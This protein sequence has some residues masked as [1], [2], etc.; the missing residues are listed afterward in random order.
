MIALH[1]QCLDVKR[2]CWCLRK[3]ADL[4][5]WAHAVSGDEDVVCVLHSV[6]TFEITF[7][8]HNGGNYLPGKY[9]QDLGK[10]PQD[11]CSFSGLNIPYEKT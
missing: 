10:T 3:F 4:L 7:V 9:H 2:T 6:L 11:L 5:L 1:A 8:L